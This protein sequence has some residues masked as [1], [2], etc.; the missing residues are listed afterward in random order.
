MSIQFFNKN[1]Y[2]INNDDDIFNDIE[3]V[4]PFINGLNPVIYIYIL[5]I[6]NYKIYKYIAVSLNN[7]SK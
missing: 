3:V 2:N 6:K 1:I 4:I 5:L 7:M